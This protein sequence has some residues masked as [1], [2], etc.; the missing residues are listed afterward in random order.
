MKPVELGYMSSGGTHFLFTPNLFDL[1]ADHTV[2]QHG[3]PLFVLAF[4][5]DWDICVA[6]AEEQVMLKL[7]GQWSFA[8][9]YLYGEDDDGQDIAH[10]KSSEPKMSLSAVPA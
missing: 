10:L 6:Q 4:A 3:K 7:G 5:K 8:K 9:D 1:P 2:D